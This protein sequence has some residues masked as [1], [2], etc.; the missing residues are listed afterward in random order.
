MKFLRYGEK[1]N[2]IADIGAANQS[3][4]GQKRLNI[5]KQKQKTFVSALVFIGKYYLYQ[6][7]IALKNPE[8]RLFKG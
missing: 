3:K 4:H 7:I 5:F 8:I 6:R 1:N 2:H